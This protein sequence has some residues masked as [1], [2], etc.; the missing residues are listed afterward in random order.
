MIQVR[1]NGRKPTSGAKQTR[2][3]TDI[4]PSLTTDAYEALKRSIAEIG[5]QEPVIE[6]DKGG[7]I[8]GRHRRQAAEEL[9]RSSCQSFPI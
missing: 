5:V 2:F 8:D 6:D 7:L 9:N 3:Y 4:F 1:K